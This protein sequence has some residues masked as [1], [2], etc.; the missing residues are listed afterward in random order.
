M[1]TGDHNAPG[2][3]ALMDIVAALQWLKENVG[4]FGGDS[5]SISLMGQGHGAALVNLLLVSPV[6]VGK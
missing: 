3:Y 4:V 1:S 5:G 6:N 2:N